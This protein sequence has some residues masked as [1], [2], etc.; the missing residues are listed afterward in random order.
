MAPLSPVSIAEA[1][2]TLHPD[3]TRIVALD[4]GESFDF[5]DGLFT[6]C[7]VGHHAGECGDFGD[8]ATVGFL[9]CF[10]RKWHADIIAERGL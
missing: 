4:E 5:R 3:K 8:P 9:F 1:G 6:G 2:L 7:T 10:D